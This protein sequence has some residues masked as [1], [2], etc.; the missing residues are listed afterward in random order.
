MKTFKE[1]KKQNLLTREEQSNLRGGYPTGT[2][3]YRG[4]DGSVECGVN[5][6]YAQYMH[7]WLGGN[8]CCDSCGSTSYCGRKLSM[9]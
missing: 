7:D 9:Y 4:K 6:A 8:W 2:C 3:G 5:K 1:L